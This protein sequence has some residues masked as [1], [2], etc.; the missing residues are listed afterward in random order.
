MIE[1][2]LPCPSDDTRHVGRRTGHGFDIE[3]DDRRALQLAKD[4]PARG[5]SWIEARFGL[6]RRSVDRMISGQTKTSALL[7]EIRRA[8]GVVYMVGELTAGERELVRLYR[9]AQQRMP[10]EAAAILIYARGRAAAIDEQWKRQEETLA[11]QARLAAE[12]EQL[13][14]RSEQRSP[15]EGAIRAHRM[16]ASSG[17]TKTV[18]RSG[19]VGRTS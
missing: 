1:H 13:A 10:D 16:P 18:G 3:D 19:R 9:G 12:R 5:L 7:P 15:K 2:P 11:G 8:L 17:G 4:D 14:R 6:D